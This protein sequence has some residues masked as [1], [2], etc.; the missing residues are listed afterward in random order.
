MKKHAHKLWWRI[1]IFVPT[2]FFFAGGL[3]YYCAPP[4]AVS[5]R[6]GAVVVDLQTLGE[7]PTTVSRIRLIDLDAGAVVWEV[8]ALNGTA[9]ISGLTLRVGVN[10]AHLKASYGNYRIVSPERGEFILS[11]TTKYRIEVWGSPAF[12]AKKSTRFTISKPEANFGGLSQKDEPAA[13]SLFIDFVQPTHPLF[14]RSIFEGH[15]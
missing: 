7:Y 8:L 14:A 2:A 3:H 1:S 4:L 15:H 13:G 11:A 12:W 6:R 10:S 9:Q 5:S